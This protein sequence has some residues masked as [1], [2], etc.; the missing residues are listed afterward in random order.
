[1]AWYINRDKS[2]SGKNESES[3]KRRH[4]QLGYNPKGNRVM[5]Q[6]NTHSTAV[7]VVTISSTYQAL[8]VS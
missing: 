2:T 8:V 7:Q 4:R 6:R 5:P 1:M 3:V